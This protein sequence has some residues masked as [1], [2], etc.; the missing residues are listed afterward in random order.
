MRWPPI[1][2]STHTCVAYTLRTSGLITQHKK[3]LTTRLFGHDPCKTRI[4]RSSVLPTPSSH[5]L[6]CSV[7]C[8]RTSALCLPQHR[9]RA[10]QN[11]CSSA[12]QHHRRLLQPSRP[13]DNLSCSYRTVTTRCTHRMRRGRRRLYNNAHNRRSRLDWIAR[14]PYIRC[15]LL[16]CRAL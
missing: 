15:D 10:Y 14:D 12:M 1:F 4:L 5:Y 3:V 13:R 16:S 9:K 2:N 6:P 8:G 11:W 7:F